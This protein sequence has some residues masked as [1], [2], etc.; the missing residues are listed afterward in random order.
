MTLMVSFALRRLSDAS[1]IIALDVIIPRHSEISFIPVAL[2]MFM[3][4][5]RIPQTRRQPL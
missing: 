1:L 3:F 2:Q 4:P 5:V